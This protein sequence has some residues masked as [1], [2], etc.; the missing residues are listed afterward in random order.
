MKIFWFL[1][2]QDDSRY[3]GAAKNARPSEHHYLSQIARAV[4]ELGYEGVLIPT[5]RTC[6]DSWIVASSLVALTQRLKFLIALRPGVISPAAAARMASTLDRFSNG[7]LLLNIVVGGDSAELAGD[8]IFQAH[9]ERYQHAEEFL[10]IWRKLLAG[11]TVDFEGKHTRIEGGRMVFPPAQKPHPPLFFGGSSP[12]R[13]KPA[14]PWT[15]ACA[16]T[17]SCAKPTR[18]PGQRP[19][20]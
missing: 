9:D 18:K 2:S 10:H 7:R 6:E 11:E 17:S 14:E 16:C 20:T 13:K 1:P 15:M 3:L 5:G 19:K 8:G 12:A 4:D